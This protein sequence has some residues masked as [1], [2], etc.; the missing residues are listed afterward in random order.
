MKHFIFLMLAGLSFNT[1]AHTQSGVLAV[2]VSTVDYYYVDCG[3]DP[4]SVSL[5][6]HI[7]SSAAAG[8][9]LVSAQVIK[10]NYASNFTDPINGDAGWS[11][12][13]VIYGGNGLYSISVNKNGAG[14]VSYSFEAHCYDSSG[15][16]TDS[17][18]IIQVN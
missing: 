12:D 13:Q 2:P 6:F 15:E 11:R 18:N 17:E 16:H 9:P 5:Y 7:A 10:D 8:M 4:S 1:F 14:V 3:S